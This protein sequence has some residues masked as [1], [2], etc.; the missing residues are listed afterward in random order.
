MLFG[1][2]KLTFA[3]SGANKHLVRGCLL[4]AEGIFPYGRVSKFVASRKDSPH[5]PVGET[6]RIGLEVGEGDSEKLKKEG[7]GVGKIGKVFIK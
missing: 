1:G 4:G 5:S 7:G 6:R 3:A 2:E